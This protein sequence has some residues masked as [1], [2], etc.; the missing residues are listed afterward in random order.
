MSCHPHL[1]TK[2]ECIYHP[3]WTPA[4]DSE[5]LALRDKGVS[6]DKIAQALM[7]QPNAVTQ[8]WHQLRIVPGIRAALKE[9]GQVRADYPKCEAMQ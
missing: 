1:R 2:L 7:R 4:Q 6:L 5:L 3:R 9:F 8:R